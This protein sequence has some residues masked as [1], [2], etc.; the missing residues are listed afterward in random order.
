MKT[1]KFLQESF[2]TKERFQQ[3]ISFKSNKIFFASN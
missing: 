1:I 3:E 2:E